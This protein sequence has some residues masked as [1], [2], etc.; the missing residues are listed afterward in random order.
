[1]HKN[2]HEAFVARRCIHFIDDGA[3][4]LVV[5]KLQICVNQIVLAMKLVVPFLVS[6]CR[7][8]RG[9]V[10]GDQLFPKAYA[11]KNVR[12]HM[13]CMRCSS[14]NLRVA[15]LP[16]RDPSGLSGLHH[17]DRSM[18]RDAGMFRSTLEWRLQNSGS[19]E[20][21]GIGLIRRGAA[22]FKVIA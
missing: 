20:L 8:G 7:K 15:L 6:F 3:G 16:L 4:T 13:L 9:G 18:M 10:G 2:P 22:T 17:E 14:C 21:M 11:R 1:M 5:R 19:L 12:G